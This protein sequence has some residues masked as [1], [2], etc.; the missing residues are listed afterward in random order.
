MLLKALMFLVLVASMQQALVISSTLQVENTTE[1]FL[2]L[3]LALAYGVLAVHVVAWFV[4]H[5]LTMFANAL[6]AKSA[7]SVAQQPVDEVSDDEK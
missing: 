6:S 7:K 3:G 2:H 5:A 4:V 1:C